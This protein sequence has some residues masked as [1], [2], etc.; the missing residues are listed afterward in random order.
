MVEIGA[1]FPRNVWEDNP[2][3]FYFYANLSSQVLAKITFFDFLGDCLIQEII[4]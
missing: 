2:F 1:I 4:F 3:T